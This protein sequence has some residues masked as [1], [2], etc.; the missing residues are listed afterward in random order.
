MLN[1][2][3]I[4]KPVPNYDGIYEISNHGNFAVLK[5]DG[6]VLRKLNS[7][8]HYLSVSCKSLNGETQ[9]TLYIHTTV[10]HVFL[11]NRPDGMIIRHLD[12]NRFNNHIDN[13]AYGTPKQNYEDVVKHKTQK[14]SNNGMAI[15]NE[16]G[17]KAIKFLVKNKISHKLLSEAFDVS[18]G[19]I[20]AITSN[21]NW[22]DV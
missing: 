3:E 9:K 12:G 2:S 13:L 6:R 21:R 14:G 16:S 7:S 17:A 8:T 5:Q 10:A 19:T 20:Y 22:K 4:W 1:L 15:I 11:G 18:L